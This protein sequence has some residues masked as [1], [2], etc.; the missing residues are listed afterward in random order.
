MAT[1]IQL[2]LFFSTLANLFFPE[3]GKS[4][5]FFGF[6]SFFKI[7][8]IQFLYRHDDIPFCLVAISY[9]NLDRDAIKA[10]KKYGY[11]HENTF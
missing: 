10:K 5:G 6:D 11:Q 2:Y 4:F 3:R 7:V 9:H 1:V 8:E